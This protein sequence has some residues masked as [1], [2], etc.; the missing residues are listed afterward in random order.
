MLEQAEAALE[1][2][3]GIKEARAGYKEMVDLVMQ[4]KEIVDEDGE[5]WKNERREKEE[6]VMIDQAANGKAEETVKDGEN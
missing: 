2:I 5:F 4:A 3:R 1:D 6:N